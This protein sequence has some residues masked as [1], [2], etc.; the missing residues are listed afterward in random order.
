MSLF[1]LIGAFLV[2]FSAGMAGMNI[3]S[4]YS[5]RPRQLR[6][7]QDALQVLDTEIMYAA[8]PLPAALRKIGQAGD[9]AVS[10]IFSAAAALLE[11]SRGYTAGEAWSRALDEEF[12]GTALD[13]DDYAVLRA[14]GEGL[15]A[16]DRQEQHKK[17]A[18]TSLHLRKEEEKAQREREKNERL[19]RYGGFLLGIS[20]VLLLL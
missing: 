12:R 15:G 18:L 2:I 19:W 8:T 14:F 17:I 7:L 9:T 1:K 13:G 3:A 20:I 6:A 4:Y 16:S 11:S 10:R 5:L